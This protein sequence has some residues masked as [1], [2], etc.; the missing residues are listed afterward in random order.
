MHVHDD[1]FAPGTPDET[2][3]HRA[4]VEGWIVLTRDTRIRYRQLELSALRAAE[5][6]A[7]VL[8]AKALTGAEM[9]EAF[10]RALPAM[11]RLVEIHEPP[12]VATVSRD[13]KIRRID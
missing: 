6:R 5:V 10:V 4:G 8:S 12:L 13:G 9:G 1:I 11:A 3:L 7:F 2:W